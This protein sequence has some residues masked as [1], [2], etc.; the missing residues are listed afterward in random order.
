MPWPRLN[1][2]K[3]RAAGTDTPYPRVLT[4]EEA[5]ARTVEGIASCR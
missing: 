2:P 1:R 4:T 5:P 3:A